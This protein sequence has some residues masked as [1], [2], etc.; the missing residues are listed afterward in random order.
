MREMREMRLQELTD[1]AIKHFRK[2]T[3]HWSMH[4]VEIDDLHQQAALEIL[5]V[6]RH[7][8]DA[9]DAYIVWV[10]A[11]KLM[12]YVLRNVWDVPT[13]SLT[14]AQNHPAD[15]MTE[16]VPESG[17]H[18]RVSSLIRNLAT[19]GRIKG[20]K[21]AQMAAQQTIRVLELIADGYS[22]TRTAEQLHLKPS[23]IRQLLARLRDRLVRDASS[24]VPPMVIRW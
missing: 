7:R 11:R 8:P 10:V 24:S 1:S 18:E 3:S 14:A 5:L 15:L 17:V 23:A 16:S 6:L 21:R 9:T 2:L 22:I 12:T 19:H 4:D 13:V 20:G